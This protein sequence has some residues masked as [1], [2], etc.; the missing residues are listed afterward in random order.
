MCKG[1]SDLRDTLT[2]SQLALS[3]ASPAF[4]GYLSDIDCRWSVISASVDDRTEEERGLKVTDITSPSPPLFF[5]V[6]LLVPQP[7]SKDKFVIPK[8]RY[9]TIDCYISKPDYNDCP[10]VYDEA[11]FKLLRDGGWRT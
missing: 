1:G 10:V 5:I 6:F 3:A 4:R 7:L 8:S 2:S 9:D 11:T